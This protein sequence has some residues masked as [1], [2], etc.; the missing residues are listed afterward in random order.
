MACWVV[1]A[2]KTVVHT[3][4]GER[5]WNA[6]VVLHWN[7]HTRWLYYGVLPPN[8]LNIYLAYWFPVSLNE[9]AALDSSVLRADAFA[10]SCGS[11]ISSQVCYTCS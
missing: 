11:V 8:D 6:E 5:N 3:T 4:T 9:T 7:K 1:C 2:E 10:A